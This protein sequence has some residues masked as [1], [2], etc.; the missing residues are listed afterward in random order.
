MTTSSPATSEKLSPEDSQDKGS[1]MLN[2]MKALSHSDT[3][4]KRKN[5]T[6]VFSCLQS[7]FENSFL[8]VSKGGSAVPCEVAK[9]SFTVTGLSLPFLPLQ[10]MTR[11]CRLINSFP[12]D[13]CLNY[14]SKSRNK[15][16]SVTVFV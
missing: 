15:A 13:A 4:A 3:S 16:L 2:F 7:I 5:Y 6:R 14:F 12:G 11:S 1:Q 10:T 8:P 9:S